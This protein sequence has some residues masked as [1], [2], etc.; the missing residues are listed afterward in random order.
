MKGLSIAVGKTLPSDMPQ[1]PLKEIN[2]LR[3]QRN[4][5][6]QQYTPSC[7]SQLTD[8]RSNYQNMF[9]KFSNPA[10]ILRNSQETQYMQTEPDSYDY[11]NVKNNSFKKYLN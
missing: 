10:K 11:Q 6:F 3:I 4:K 7:N 5:I 2:S 1:T 9:Q 8:A